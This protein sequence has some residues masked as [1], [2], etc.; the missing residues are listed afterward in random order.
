MHRYGLVPADLKPLNFVT[1]QFFHVGWIHLIF[2]LLFLFLTGPFIEDVWGRRFFGSLLSSGG[3]FAGL[4]FA[5][6]FP[7][8]QTPLV[9]AS[10]AIAAV[11]GAF[12]VRFLKSKIR[13]ILWIFVPAGPV[14]ST[15]LGDF[16]VVVR[17]P[18]P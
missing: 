4:M 9:G 13:F 16:A 6:R 11:M 17:D 1:Y 3:A 14:S 15:G 8:L 18:A 10:G 7:E 5:I 12:L 2:N